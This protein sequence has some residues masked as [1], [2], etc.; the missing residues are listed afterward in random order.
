M[1]QHAHAVTARLLPDGNGSAAP[2]QVVDNA[3][4]AP[5]W[6]AV[7]R[8]TR[9]APITS[10]RSVPPWQYG[11]ALLAVD[12]LS[13]LA[14][15]FARCGPVVCPLR[16]DALFLGVGAASSVN[17]GAIGL[18]GLVTFGLWVFAVRRYRV[19]PIAVA[20]VVAGIIA[21][22]LDRVL[23]GSVR[24]FLVIPGGVVINVA[25][26]A[27]VGGLFVCVATVARA[28]V[29]SQLLAKGGELK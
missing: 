28:V 2:C 23:L 11:M 25:D 10:F 20:F 5:G 4:A 15:G 22:T 21:N 1:T 27:D 24:D 13:K 18:I 14:A 17:A 16:N 8:P 7:A 12:Q 6:V 29:R 3:Q 19:R 9:F 26:V